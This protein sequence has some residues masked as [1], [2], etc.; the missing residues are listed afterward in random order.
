MLPLKDDSFVIYLEY[1]YS[2]HQ[3]IS[4]PK[5]FN[6]KSPFQNKFDFRSLTFVKRQITLSK[7]LFWK[8]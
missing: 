2:H 8:N 4:H 5:Y 3:I 6:E 1:N 7:I